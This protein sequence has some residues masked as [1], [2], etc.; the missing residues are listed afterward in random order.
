MDL[1]LKSD[2]KKNYYL[3]DHKFHE[4][5]LWCQN[6]PDPGVQISK[7]NLQRPGLC[8]RERAGSLQKG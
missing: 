4:N 6:N 1:V 7:N 3:L 2:V 5:E 8:K